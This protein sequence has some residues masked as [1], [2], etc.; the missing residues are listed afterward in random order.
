MIYDLIR[1]RRVD[2]RQGNAQTD[3]IQL[4]SWVEMTV[5]SGGQP[6]TGRLTAGLTLRLKFLPGLQELGHEKWYTNQPNYLR[7]QR[8][9][10]N[11]VDS[12]AVS[13]LPVRVWWQEIPAEESRVAFYQFKK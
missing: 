13:R 11:V 9:E 6:G 10:I 7:S 5:E 1:D 2:V 3:S 4:S 8:D 12:Q